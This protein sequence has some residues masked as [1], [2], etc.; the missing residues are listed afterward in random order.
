R[1]PETEIYADHVKLNEVAG[2]ILAQQQISKFMIE[3]GLRLENHELYG[4][5]WIPQAG[6]SYKA[7]KQTSLKFSFSKGFRSPNMR[8]LYMYG[9][10]NEDLLPERSFSYDFTVSQRLLDS[11]MSMELTLFYIEGDN[12]IEVVQVGESRVQNRNTG[13]FANKGIEFSMNYRIIDNLILNTNYSLLDMEKAI[14]GAPR[15]K[16][17]AG[18]NYHPGKFTLSAGTQVIDKLYL[19]TGEKPRTTDYTVV[20]ARL[21]YRALDWMEIFVK[22]DNLLGEKYETMNGY[23]MPGATFMG[24]ISLNL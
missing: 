6:I 8:E 10:A 12:L 1:N 5:E 15:N 7:A 9:P 17:Y 23:P 20:N 21:A 19:V 4:S 18:I 3:A 16:F 13:E 24:G 14:T 11:R 22:G 2:Y